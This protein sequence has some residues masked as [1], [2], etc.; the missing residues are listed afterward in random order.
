MTRPKKTPTIPNADGDQAK[1]TARAQRLRREADAL[2]SGK[3]ASKPSS[4]SP[5]EFVQKEMA[6]RGAGKPR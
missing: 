5:R 4:S 6:K 2:A 3:A 1:R